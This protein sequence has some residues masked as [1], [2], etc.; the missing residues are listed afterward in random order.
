MNTEHDTEAMQYEYET[1]S[2]IV[3]FAILNRDL[4]FEKL[5]AK[6]R[7]LREAIDAIVAIEEDSPAAYRAA[8]L[9]AQE[10]QHD[11]AV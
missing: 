4:R 11:F 5:N 7:I 9:I 2:R 8:K 1:V 10:A 6:T 3:K